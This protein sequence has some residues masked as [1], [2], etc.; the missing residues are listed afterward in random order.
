VANLFVTSDHH[1]GHAN[2]LTFEKA[3][4]TKLRP[5]FS[6][7]NEMDE[8]MVQ[9]WNETVGPK[10]K[11]YHLGDFAMHK[12]FISFYAGALNGELRIVLGNHDDEN[13][14]LYTGYFDDKGTH[15]PG[16]FKKVFGS[17]K[18]D[19]FLLSHIPVHPRSLKPGQVNLHGHVHNNG[20]QGF[21]GPQY[22]N[23]CVEMHGYKPVALEDI[24]R[25]VRLIQDDY[26][27]FN[28]TMV[29]GQH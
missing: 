4:G 20:P 1:F 19:N 7:V 22:F 6:N 24:K 11:V 13:V 10:D 9:M 15:Y 2:I 29:A 27:A 14:K 26:D 5:E 18:L 23:M 17:R 3:D 21:L 28:A 12:R 16:Y 8:Y 25:Q